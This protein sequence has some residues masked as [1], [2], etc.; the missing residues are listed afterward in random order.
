VLSASKFK[1]FKT[2][3]RY[4]FDVVNNFNVTQAIN[5]YLV[6][7]SRQA[8]NYFPKFVATFSMLVANQLLSQSI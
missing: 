1:A 4:K 2:L 7:T 3:Y 8:N 5:T 6:N